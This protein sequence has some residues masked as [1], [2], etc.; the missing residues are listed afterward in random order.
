MIHKFGSSWSN[1]GQ[2]FDCPF[3]RSFFISNGIF[4]TNWNPRGDLLH[5]Y[6]RIFV[7][8]SW[9]SGR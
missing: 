1:I 9:K 6:S 3:N 8:L 7:G 2:L 5:M 4:S